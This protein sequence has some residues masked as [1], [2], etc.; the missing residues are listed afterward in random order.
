MMTSI[1]PDLVTIQ[2][3][4]DFIAD[5]FKTADDVAPDDKAAVISHIEYMFE[6]F[7]LEGCAEDDWTIPVKRWIV[8]YKS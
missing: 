2:K 7:L 5:L 4:V 3:A 8:D 6:R 1:M